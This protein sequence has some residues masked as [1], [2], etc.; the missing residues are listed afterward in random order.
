MQPPILSATS[1]L[2]VSKMARSERLG[3]N[4]R[5]CTR[6]QRRQRNQ[7]SPTATATSNTE[8]SW[9]QQGKCINPEERKRLVENQARDQTGYVYHLWH[10]V[11]SD[12]CPKGVKELAR[13]YTSPELAKHDALCWLIDRQNWLGA[14]T[15]DYWTHV[16]WDEEHE[17]CCYYCT[18]DL[19]SEELGLRF[20]TWTTT[21]RLC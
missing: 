18:D 1:H 6:S 13:T 19:L 17:R 3:S 7:T 21:A 15:E 2:F 20:Y 16:A 4:F 9:H 8:P 5:A 10:G 14:S 11:I 12:N